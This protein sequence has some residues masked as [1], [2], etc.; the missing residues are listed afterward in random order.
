MILNR[1]QNVASCLS[2]AA[3]NLTRNTCTPSQQLRGFLHLCNFTLTSRD[4][5][6]HRFAIYVL[7]SHSILLTVKFIHRCLAT[8]AHFICA[9]TLAPVYDH[10]REPA[11][12]HGER[13]LDIGMVSIRIMTHH[14]STPSS[15]TAT[16]ASKNVLSFFAV[17]V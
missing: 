1:L 7:N 5:L 9:N 10:I 13:P 8:T 4:N 2:I 16:T 14:L 15:I 11:D 17:A 12:G 3:S 6:R